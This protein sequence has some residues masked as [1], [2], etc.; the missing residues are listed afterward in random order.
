MGLFFVITSKRSV[1]VEY[2]YLA[3]MISVY[4]IKPAFQKLL[5]PVLLQLHKAGITANQITVA[6]IVLSGGLGYLFLHYQEH[7]FFLLLVP[8]GLLLRMALNALDGMMAT[9]YKMQSKKGEALNEMGDVISDIFI[10][11]PFVV[12]PTA[13][14]FV[15]VMFGVLAVINEFSGV[16]GKAMGGERR[17]EG[18]MGKSDRALVIGLFCL[19]SYFWEDMLLYT[20]WV[21]L[22][23]SV[24]MLFS[25]YVR[26]KKA[27]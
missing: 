2:L 12:I 7:R 6:A 5:Q 23:A 15:I 17:Y 13:N 11:F 1:S 21:F 14:P 8:L 19:V 18:P 26:L 22:L 9:Q 25:T 24:L 3:R 27:I 4:K 10:I 16:L 20:D